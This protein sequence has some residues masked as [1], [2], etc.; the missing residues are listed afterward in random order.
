MKRFLI[1]LVTML[2]AIVIIA[3]KAPSANAETISHFQTR[4]QNCLYGQ[5]YRISPVP[6]SASGWRADTFWPYPSGSQWTLYVGGNLVN[7]GGNLMQRVGDPWLA[8]YYSWW[9]GTNADGTVGPR[10]LISEPVHYRQSD[11]NIITACL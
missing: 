4:V 8:D 3:A 7:G 1:V 2:A 6:Y 9:Y 11:R 5:F 10:G